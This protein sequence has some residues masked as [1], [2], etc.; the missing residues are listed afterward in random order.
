MSR[1][2][3]SRVAPPP[4][5]FASLHC[6][7]RLRHWPSALSAAIPIFYRFRFFGDDAS[8]GIYQH[9]LFFQ[10]YLRQRIALLVEPHRQKL[11]FSL[12]LLLDAADFV[13]SLIRCCS[14]PSHNRVVVL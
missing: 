8:S 2:D 3:G 5:I 9:R 13:E 11:R 12:Q 10:Y 1:V 14:E 7:E 6:P 4:T